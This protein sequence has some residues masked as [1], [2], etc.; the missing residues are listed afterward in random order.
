MNSHLIEPHGGSLVNLM[1]FEKE[2]TQLLRES[3][4]WP[5]WV[6]TQRQLCDL[7]LLLNGGFSPLKGYMNRS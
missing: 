6:L 5:S 1:V 7:E 4:D 3:K 2:A